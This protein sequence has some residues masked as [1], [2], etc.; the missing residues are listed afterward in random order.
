METILHYWPSS[1]GES[2]SLRVDFSHAWYGALLFFLYKSVQPTEQTAGFLVNWDALTL[3]WSQCNEWDQ[4]RLADSDLG[5]LLLTVDDF[6]PSM[7]K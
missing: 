1:W 3:T 7:G 4:E 2:I 5:A 6:N